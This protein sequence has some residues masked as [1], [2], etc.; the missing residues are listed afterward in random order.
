MAIDENGV[1]IPDSFET[2]RDEIQSKQNVMGTKMEIFET[3]EY[4]SMS[5]PI[6][7]GIY[8]IQS[9]VASLPAM[10]SNELSMQEVYIERSGVNTTD[11][12]TNEAKKS[13]FIDYAEIYNT[14]NPKVAQI[15][16][17]IWKDDIDFPT[18]DLQYT[19]NEIAKITPVFVPYFEDITE[20][21]LSKI[22]ICPVS[23]FIK[24]RSNL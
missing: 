15:E 13:E 18:V 2:I 9:V 10:V 23:K 17:Y 3:S 20:T 12:I 1:Y 5:N 7:T 22:Y 14:S 11:A 24:H 16:L 8:N 21:V 6:I 4:Q 19:A